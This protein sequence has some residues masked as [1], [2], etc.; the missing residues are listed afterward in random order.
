VQLELGARS[1][2]DDADVDLD[3]LGILVIVLLI[4]LIAKLLGN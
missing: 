4:V 2:H 3:D 1:N